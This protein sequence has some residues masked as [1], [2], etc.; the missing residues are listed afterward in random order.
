MNRES[1]NY[2]GRQLLNFL[3]DIHDDNF[4]DNFLF[5]ELRLIELTLRCDG[6]VVRLAIKHIKYE[7]LRI[8]YTK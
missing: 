3:T 7:H 1:T 8:N 6:D 2:D 5:F 4:F